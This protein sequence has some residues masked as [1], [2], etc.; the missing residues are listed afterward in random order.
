MQTDSPQRPNI[1]LL[2]ADQ[3]AAAALP[4]YGHGVVQAPALAR[5]AEQG[6]VF[7]AAWKR[8]TTQNPD[9][10][11]ASTEK[12]GL[13]LASCTDHPFMVSSPAMARQVA[14]FRIRLLG[15]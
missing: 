1:V 3:L 6:M 15:L 5:A 13:I 12:I 7:D 10:A 11:M 9:H 14:D 8:H 4:V 2:M